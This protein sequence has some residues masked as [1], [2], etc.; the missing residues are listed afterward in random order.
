MID[1]LAASEGQTSEEYLA[2]LVSEFED[3][4]AGDDDE[5]E[6]GRGEDDRGQ[7]PATDD[8]QAAPAAADPEVPAKDA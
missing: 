4:G 8:A 3:T 1:D 7:A 6:D 5:V 2:M